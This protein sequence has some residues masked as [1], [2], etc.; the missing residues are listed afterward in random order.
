M[1]TQPLPNDDSR[2]LHSPGSSAS[3]SELQSHDD[4]GH[5]SRDQYG[6]GAAEGSGRGS[7][8]SAH[9]AAA[10]DSSLSPSDGAHR[11][12]VDEVYPEIARVRKRNRRVKRVVKVAC[13][14]L[15]ALVIA[16]AGF[17][18][19]FVT[20]LDSALAPD[21]ETSDELK[22]VL[23]PPVEG[24]PFYMLLMGSDSREGN[25]ADHVLESGNNERSDV[26]I[27]LRVDAK[28]KKVTML[29][30]PRDTAYG[31][32]DGSYVKINEMYNHSGAAGEVKAVSDVTG[33]A[34]SHHAEVRISGLESI[35]DLLGG[36]T[37]DVPTEMTYTTTDR[38]KVT[39]KEGRQTL[40]G[41][42]AQIF[43]R[44]RHEFE[45]DQDEH[46]QDNVRQLLLAIID[47]V[48]SR[49]V[50]ELPGI[51]LQV[52]NYI[53]T[54]MTSADALSLAMAFSSGDMT[55]YSGTGPSNGDINEAAG[56]KWL[57][58]LNPEGWKAVMDVVD[59]GD[60]PKA[61]NIDYAA[62]EIPWS[63]VEGQPEFLDS[64]AYQYYYQ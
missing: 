24:E 23:I 62:T 25:V 45:T 43:A 27:L 22:K 60:D 40:N 36:V 3:N 10:S 28:H 53:D 47:E 18:I 63:E 50:T 59:A 48:L 51:V 5:Y 14:V 34:I 58:Y 20:Q 21:A 12:T 54:D 38:Q 49:P 26:I 30:I 4:A 29:S 16:G 13:C 57:C 46:R 15:A 56:K 61:A 6:N 1:T 44:A 31:L 11:V 33:A 7:G 8:M 32:E 41:Q 17:G 9:H 19:W 39:I 35:V 52:A 55:V 2:D 42:E 37:V 64:L